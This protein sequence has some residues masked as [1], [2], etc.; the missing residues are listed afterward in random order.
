M[1]IVLGHTVPFEWRRS[2]EGL[3]DAFSP[4][5]LL[6]LTCV[7]PYPTHCPQGQLGVTLMIFE[8]GMHMHYDEI[9]HVWYVSL[10]QYTGESVL[11][12]LPDEDVKLVE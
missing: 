9:L 11:R 3:Q 12:S 10:V 7:E 8:S 5:C 4:L 1:C 2:N 6:K